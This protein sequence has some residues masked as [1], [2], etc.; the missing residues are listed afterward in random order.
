MPVLLSGKCLLPLQ[1]F[2][3]HSHSTWEIILNLEGN[4]CD[5]VGA[6]EFP[7]SPG[8]I[9]CIP[10][11]IHHSKVSREQ[12][13]DI[14]LQSTEFFL[15]DRPEVLCLHDDEDKSVETLMQLAYRTFNKQEKNCSN[16][17]DSLYDSIQAILLNMVKIPIRNQ[18]TEQ[19]IN[20]ILKSY[21]DPEFDASDAIRTLPYC[22]DYIRRLFRKETGMTPVAYLNNVRLEHAKKLLMQQQNARYTIGDIAWMCGFYD[23]KY[24]TRLFKSYTTLSPKQY[25][26]K[27][28]V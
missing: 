10:P 16:I 24:F 21:S 27:T 25:A 4:G 20:L 1:H 9:I 26:S 14:Y 2:C 13:K 6:E 8:T 28:I 11:N 17:V 7:F 23:S 12:F 19:L 15:N 18:S 22:K 5:I 3:I